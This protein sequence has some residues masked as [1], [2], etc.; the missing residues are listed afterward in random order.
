MDLK[1][2]K[3]RAFFQ[4]IKFEHTVFA[5]PFAYLGLVLAEDGLPSLSL[6]CWVT[7]AMV[8][9]RTFGMIVNR[10][11]DEPIDLKNPRTEG[12]IV[13]M[14][15][16]S[17]PVVCGLG[18]TS[19][20]LFVFAASRI[21]QLCL[22]L[23]PIPVLLMCVYPHLKKFTWLSHFFLGIILGIAPYAGWLASG[24]GWA[25]QPLILTVVVAS[26]VAGFDLFYALQDIAFD[27]F[28]K[29]ESFP[30]HFGERKTL[31]TARILH[32]VTLASLALTGLAFGLGGWY[33]T[34]FTIVFALIVREHQLIARHGLSKL[35]EAFFNMN[36]WVSIV[37][38]FGVLLDVTVS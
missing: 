35:N 17:R 21:N 26:W 6:F 8:A 14:E 32:F 15:R 19:I 31:L 29:L 5:L 30:A 3:T 9:V 18:F 12:R 7:L 27:R 25:F 28:E 36:A 22:M 34:G 10:I 11:V 37:I 16:V 1:I 2:S 33:W 4:L 38:F 13:L 23:S 24:G 20:G